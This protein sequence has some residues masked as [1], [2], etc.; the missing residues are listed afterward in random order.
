MSSEN[1][2]Y[3]SVRERLR[4]TRKT[5]NLTQEAFGRRVGMRRQ[6]VNAIESGVRNPGLVILYRIAV[7]YHL[8]LDWILL[9][10]DNK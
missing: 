9:G 3:N 4:I 1:I 2:D 5:L 7:V 6:D 8:S 10:K